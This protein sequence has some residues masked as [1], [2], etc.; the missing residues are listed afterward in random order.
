VQL[1][2]TTHLWMHD[3][4]IQRTV[5]QNALVRQARDAQ[6]KRSGHPIA[7]F[8]VSRIRAGLSSLR[9]G[10]RPAGTGNA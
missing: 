9:R 7:S 10:L 5:K 4:E 1:D 2:P 8:R 3:Q 6:A